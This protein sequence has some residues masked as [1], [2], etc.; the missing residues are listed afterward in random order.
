M[1]DVIYFTFDTNVVRVV[2]RNIYLYFV[3]DDIRKIVGFEKIPEKAFSEQGWND[4][5]ETIIIEN[6]TFTIMSS[7]AVFRILSF[8]RR[9]KV[10]LFEKWLEKEVID[11]FAK[12]FEKLYSRE[13]PWVNYAYL[14]DGYS[15]EN[16]I[17][18]SKFL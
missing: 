7:N 2:N 6:E 10:K 15:F 8:F 4:H 18:V 14:P 5:F 11:Y 9:K 13:R 1:N 3:L 17:F 12:E 16:N